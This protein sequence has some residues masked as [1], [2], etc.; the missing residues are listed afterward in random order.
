MAS[1]GWPNG[2]KKRRK[3]IRVRADLLHRSFDDPR[4]RPGGSG[5]WGREPGRL[6]SGRG[7]AADR[8]RLLHRCRRAEHDRRVR[9]SR[10][11]FLDLPPGG[12]RAAFG[13]FADLIDLHSI[14]VYGKPAEVVVALLETR[15]R[16]WATTSRLRFMSAGPDS[17]G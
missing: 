2:R 7:A 9:P 15:R 6:H 12:G 13:G 8:L 16:C 3:E 10:R 14:E 4:R 17:S 11:R 1:V 5:T